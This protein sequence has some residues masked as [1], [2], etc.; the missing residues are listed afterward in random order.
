M[1][2][3][4][5]GT[6]T[7]AIFAVLV[8]LGG[9]FVVRQHLYKPAL[10]PLPVVQQKDEIIV[11]VALTDLD[12]GRTVTINDVALKRMTLDG[13][14]KSPYAGKP[15]LRAADQIANRTLRAALRQGD[16]FLPENLYPEGMGPDLAERLQAGYRAVTVPIENIGAVLGFARA[17]SFVDV[18]FRVEPGEERPEVTMTLLERVEVLAIDSYTN[19]GQQVQ[20]EQDG[21]VT[22]AVTPHQAK[23]LKVVEGRGA[24]TLTL[25]NN[26]D[27]FESVPFDLGMN[28]ENSRTAGIPVAYTADSAA[29]G[30]LNH[31]IGHASERVSLEDL[32]GLPRQPKKLKME[33]YLGSQLEVH[34]FDRRNGDDFDQ[35]MRGGR[36]RTPIARQPATDPA[37]GHSATVGVNTL[38]PAALSAGG[39]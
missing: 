20:L 14:S 18:L 2:R 6:M 4:N 25:R 12:A 13:F 24:L 35:L 16:I 38:N 7:V 19:P 17:G 28:A 39:Q 3:L 15:Y 9:A 34:E 31:T 23:M 22:L 8:G 11:P 33:I 30:D 5:P 32:L 10:P 26:E 21:S 36:I 1:G 37:G 29:I 27:R